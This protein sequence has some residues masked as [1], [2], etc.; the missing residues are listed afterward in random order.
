MATETPQ[1]TEAASRELE[2]LAKQFPAVRRLLA[3]T[4]ELK[5]KIEAIE[6]EIRKLE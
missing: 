3:E 6:N 1:L 5:A 4:R 2:K